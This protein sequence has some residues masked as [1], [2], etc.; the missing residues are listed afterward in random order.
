[1]GTAIP[2]L[3]LYAIAAIIALP[4]S[5]SCGSSSQTATSP[6]PVRCS[7]QIQAETSA[8]PPAGGSSA[9]RITTNRECTWSARSEAGWLSVANPAEGQ[10][11]GTVQFTVAGNADPSPRGTGISVNDQR[12]PISQ[13][14]RP[15]QLSVSSDFEQ[16]DAAGGDRTIEV[17][18]NADACTWTASTNDPWISI[19]A[20]REGHG[21]GN[22]TFRV[23]PLTGA[24]RSGTLT[25]AGR[26]VQVVQLPA[27]APV[28]PAPPVPPGPGCTYSL[29]TTA[30]NVS[31][32]GG[33]SQIA[34]ITPNGCGWSARSNVG[35][36]TIVGSPFGSGPAVV[37]F[38]VEAT[39]GASRTGT[40]TI[41]EQTLTVVQAAGCSYVVDPTF[42]NAAELRRI[43]KC[44]RADGGRMYLVERERCAVDHDHRGRERQRTRK[45]RVHDRRKLRN[46]SSGIA[47]GRG[48]DGCRDAN[49]R[50]RV[51]HLAVLAVRGRRGQH[52][53]RV[54][55]DIGGLS[56]DRVERRIVDHD[57]RGRKR[58]RTWAGG[59]RGRGE[60]GPRTPGVADD[61]RPHVLGFTRERLLGPT[62]RH[63]VHPCR[64]RRAPVR[65]RSRRAPDVR[66]PRRAALPGSRSQAVATA[67][68]LGRSVI[69]LARTRD[70]HVNHR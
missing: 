35:W 58:Q 70:L 30:M 45:G 12:L 28:P 56:V 19:V 22:V 27:G 16:M 17:N 32:S 51:R 8:F 41:A 24:S 63:R 53:H 4:L 43:R 7:L 60:S 33:S 44:V 2:S 1:M 23:T 57:Y 25:L 66:G 49:R 18:A 55:H 14:G 20:G 64:R 10:G 29:A 42:H 69:R 13:E 26:V 52:W 5:L 36:M 38:A 39:A 50:L 54:G 21:D 68:A 62:S 31:Q 6:T 37:T 9:L 46:G 59:L 11:D 15:C 40:L 65:C 47:D 34:I 61:R 3:R 67:V 48:P